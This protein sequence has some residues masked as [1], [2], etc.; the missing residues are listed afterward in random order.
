MSEF[1]VNNIQMAMVSSTETITARIS[2][3]LTK[4]QMDVDGTQLEDFNKRIT[5]EEMRT[6]ENIAY[7]KGLT[8]EEM[9]TPENIAYF[10]GL[11]LEVLIEQNLITSP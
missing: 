6:P 11:V 4:M 10:K 1:F 9:R 2:L 3:S 8:N 5:N 7:F